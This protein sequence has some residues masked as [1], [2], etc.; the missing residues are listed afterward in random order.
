MP[1]LE[2]Q[3]AIIKETLSKK[4][5]ERREVASKTHR[6][7]ERKKIDSELLEVGDAQ[8]TGELIQQLLDTIGLPPQTKRFLAG[9]KKFY[10][11]TKRM[12]IN[13]KK[14]VLKIEVQLNKDK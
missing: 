14:A 9:V 2:E 11:S 6:R 4:A 5:D 3:K 8:R 1:T 7:R 12:T 13:Q 10:R